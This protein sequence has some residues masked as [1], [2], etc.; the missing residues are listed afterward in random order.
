MK[1]TLFIPA[2]ILSIT[3]YSCGNS[4]AENTDKAQIEASE[5]ATDSEENDYV[6]PQPISLANA[7]KEAGL[8]YIA[9]KTNAIDKVDSYSLKIDQLL[10][11]GVYS[12]D[13][14]YSAINGKAQEARD[15]LSAIQKLGNKVGLGSVFNDKEL[16]AKFDKELSN[17]EQLEDLIY[18]IQDKTDVYM[19]NNDLK[20]LGDVQFAGAWIEGM[21][22]GVEQ[23]SQKQDI[24]KTLVQQMSLLKN[25]LKGLNSNP[26]KEDARL[27]AIISNF[28][29]ILNT[30]EGFASV[31]KVGKNIN[32]ETPQLSADEFKALSEKVIGA[33]TSI[34]NP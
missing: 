27:K 28:D 30:Y 23:Y 18:E 4:T 13:L 16:V 32:V 2:A 21:Y 22:L 3:I 9:G 24:G 19:E 26:A 33:R 29:A 15:Y 17:P 8:A 31:K 34:V 11:L 6:L 5:T 20:Y 7:F 1:Y 10:N 12:T 14:A 25:I